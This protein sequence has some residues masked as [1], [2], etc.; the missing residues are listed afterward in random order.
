M[1]RKG[2][3]NIIT[4]DEPS[5]MNRLDEVIK[6][7]H[8]SFYAKKYYERYSSLKIVKTCVRPVRSLKKITFSN[9]LEKKPLCTNERIFKAVLIHYLVVGVQ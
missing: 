1:N 6:I 4:F 3:Y 2:Y 7:L 9:F 5:R 8:L